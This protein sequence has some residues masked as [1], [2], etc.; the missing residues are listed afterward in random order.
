MLSHPK[1]IPTRVSQT[2][3][4]YTETARRRREELALADGISIHHLVNERETKKEDGHSRERKQQKTLSSLSSSSSIQFSLLFLLFP[5][6]R[7]LE[8]LM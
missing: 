1:T 8:G 2:L 5:W 6:E 7:E 4:A 3:E